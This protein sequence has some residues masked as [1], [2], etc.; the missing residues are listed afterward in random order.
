MLYCA[1]ADPG[2]LRERRKR[3]VQLTDADVDVEKGQKLPERSHKSWQYPRP[4]RR[5]DHYCKWINNTIAL[6]NHRE[7]VLM[8]FFLT[9]V[10]VIGIVLDVYVGA[11]MARSAFFPGEVWIML[12][13]TYCVVLL[14]VEVPIFRVHVGLVCRNELAKEW[15]DNI[16]FIANNTSQGDR[17]PVHSLDDDEYNELFDRG[18]FV[19]DPSKNRWDRGCVTNCLNFWCWPRWPADEKGDF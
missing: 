16:H 2:Q 8:L 1:V 13:L 5:Y 3:K 19:Y 10:G 15:K 18:A 11:L 6:L 9:L 17:V 14:V 12:H 7:F 4:V